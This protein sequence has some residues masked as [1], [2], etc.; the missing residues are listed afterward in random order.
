MVRAGCCGGEEKAVLL[1]SVPAVAAT[2]VFVFLPAL[3]GIRASLSTWQGFGPMNF[4][5]LSNYTS[6]LHNPLF[7][8]S[9]RTTVLFTALSTV[10]IVGMGLVSPRP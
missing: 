1:L 3:Q 4:V 6:A 2:A 9:M 7:W 5:G 8:Q 10:G